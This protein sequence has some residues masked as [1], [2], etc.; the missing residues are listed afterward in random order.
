MNKTRLRKFIV[1]DDKE[2]YPIKHAEI[3]M[4]VVNNSMIFRKRKPLFE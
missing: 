1:F 4:P 3:K 2:M